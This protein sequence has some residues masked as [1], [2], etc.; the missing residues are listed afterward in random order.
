MT[1]QT[2]TKKVERKFR[3]CA[4]RGCS[5]CPVTRR[6]VPE[7]CE[8]LLKHVLET[9]PERIV[10]RKGRR[11]GK[12]SAVIRQALEM[13]DA[14]YDAIVLVP[15]ATQA[16]ALQRRLMG[17]GVEI[18]CACNIQ[19][20]R[21]ALAGRCPATVF[22]DEVGAWVAREVNRFQSHAF[23]IGYRT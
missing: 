4:G 10:I 8:F 19:A 17:T 6:L 21:R 2:D 3:V 1:N 18:L 20:V 9:E 7:D 23:V 11:T 12:T 13:A 15:D 14:G 16:H 5:K 22:S